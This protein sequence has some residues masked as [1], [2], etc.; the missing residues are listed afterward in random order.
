MARRRRPSTASLLLLV[1]GAVGAAGAAGA[2]LFTTA[3]VA[4]VARQTV[5]RVLVLACSEPS[6]GD[7]ALRALFAVIVQCRTACSME[8]ARGVLSCC[9][10]ALASP[11]AETRTCGAQL[12]GACVA[13]FDD[14]VLQQTLPAQATT[15][16]SQPSPSL[17]E[18]KFQIPHYLSVPQQDVERSHACVH[19]NDHMNTK[20]RRYKHSC[21]HY[22]HRASCARV[23]F[24]RLEPKPAASRRRASCC[25]PV[26]SG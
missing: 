21:V 22:A 17:C 25:W 7:A 26:W 24:A 2:G 8:N 16:A 9:A 4:A 11:A 18:L 19:V 1:A 12:C 14:H 23:R 10:A 20:R 3:C 6:L 13:A 5:A 15:S